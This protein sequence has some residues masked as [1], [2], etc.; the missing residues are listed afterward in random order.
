MSF[1]V[2]GHIAQARFKVL[3]E[4]DHHMKTR[5][6]QLGRAHRNKSIPHQRSGQGNHTGPTLWTLIST[7]LIMTIFAK[8]HG[9]RLLS[10]TSL[11]LISLVC[12][13]FGD[14]TDL[15]GENIVRLF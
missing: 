6:G 2:S 5:F 12:F 7:K 13:A 4:A 10:A 14:N 8:S 15:P 1:L 3:E 9:V 11:T